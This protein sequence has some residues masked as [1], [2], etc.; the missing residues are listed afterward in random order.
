[1][2]DKLKL[3]AESQEDLVILSAAL[4]DAILRVGEIHYSAR[5]RH[6]DLR[7][8]R[9]ANESKD[10]AA[11][12]L[13]GLRVDGVINLQSKGI[14]RTDPE[15]MMVLLSMDFAPDS[16]PP[17]GILSLIFAGGG[18]IRAQLEAIDVILADVSEPRLTD[19]KPLHPLEAE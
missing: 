8:S 17:G 4:Q 16:T 12:V 18:I 7:L 2:T 15:A 10:P 11:R 5:E 19:K 1:M 6:L 3:R 9:F 14:D 13:T